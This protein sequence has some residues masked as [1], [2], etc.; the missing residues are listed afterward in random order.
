MS[1]I[2]AIVDVM[3]QKMAKIRLKIIPNSVRY[4][5]EGF[6]YQH[7][8]TVYEFALYCIDFLMECITKKPFHY[9]EDAFTKRQKQEE[10]QLREELQKKYGHTGVFEVMESFATEIKGMNET[11]KDT[12]M[13]ILK[14]AILPY[15]NYNWLSLLY[16]FEDTFLVYMKYDDCYDEYKIDMLF[17]TLWEGPYGL[18]SDV[19]DVTVKADDIVIDAGSWIGDFAAYASVKGAITYAFEP[20][21]E[22]YELLTA[23]ASFNQNIYPV[24]KGLGDKKINIKF[25]GDGSTGSRILSRES[26]SPEH[27]QLVEIETT[28]IDDFVEENGLERVDFIKADIEGYERHML[29]GAAKTLKKFAPKLAL[30]TYH[31]PGDPEVMEKL[32]KEANPA[33]NV[34]QKRKKLFASVPKR[35]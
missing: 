34:V 33:Y 14:D 22:N 6:A 3:A 5:H 8:F 28:T 24:K 18:R 4:S 16:V 35:I 23:T 7:P 27:V 25:M 11:C 26:L 20:D 32:I 30:C 19:V 13:Y 2:R 12:G 1:K 17:D 29:K 15:W 21:D 31:L 9:A 10:L